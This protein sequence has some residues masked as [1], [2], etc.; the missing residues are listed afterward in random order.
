MP[1]AHFHARFDNIRDFIKFCIV[2]PVLLYQNQ[3]MLMCW[4]E[5]LGKR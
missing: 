2:N 1:H 5:I 3:D 4:Q